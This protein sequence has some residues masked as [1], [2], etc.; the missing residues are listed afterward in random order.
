[1]LRGTS[2]Q[3]FANEVQGTGNLLGDH[4]SWCLRPPYGEMDSATYSNAAA[5]GY[6]IVFWHTDS[7]D[8]RRPGVAAIVS[9]VVDNVFPGAIILMHDGAGDRS[10]TLEALPQILQ[11]LTERGYRFEPICR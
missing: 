4:N 2:F 10:Q 6:Q 8:W 1:M 3:T 9:N 5:L 7:W 11:I